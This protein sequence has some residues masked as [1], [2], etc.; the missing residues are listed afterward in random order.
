[1]GDTGQTRQTPNGNGFDGRLKSYLGWA[2]IV[3][4]LAAQLGV[5][6]AQLA[7][8]REDTH[9]HTA[10][11]GDLRLQ[12]AEQGIGLRGVERRMAI[13]ELRF[14][15]ACLLARIRGPSMGRRKRRVR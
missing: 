7:A 9:A 10:A 14:E 2:V 12:V 4:G 15:E 5:I 11:L 1:M 8:V 3:G 6:S 13:L